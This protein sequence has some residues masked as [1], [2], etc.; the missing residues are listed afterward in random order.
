[1]PAD[2]VAL[3]AMYGNAFAHSE[4]CSLFA[5]DRMACGL[6]QIADKPT[7]ALLASTAA[8]KCCICRQVYHP[9]CA[10]FFWDRM[11]KKNLD[12]APLDPARDRQ[13]LPE[14]FGVTFGDSSAFVL[15][16]EADM[17]AS[18]LSSEFLYQIVCLFGQ[19]VV[20]F[21]IS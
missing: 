19:V 20:T 5:E 1:M 11:S 16:G 14:C 9:T 6:C 13:V 7:G 17:S 10:R 4:R 12:I 3:C 8:A 15:T 18:W 2:V 21:L